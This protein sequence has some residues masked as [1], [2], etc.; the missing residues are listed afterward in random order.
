MPESL[1]LRVD[2]VS[3]QRRSDAWAGAIAYTGVVGVGMM[4]ALAGLG[5]SADPFSLALGV[6]LFGGAAILVRPILGVYLIVFFTLLGDSETMA[7]Y[8]AYRNFSSRE[9]MLYVNDAM[10]FTPVEVW[11]ALTII[12]L[13]VHSAGAREWNLRGRPLVWPLIALALM[14]GVGLFYGVGLRGGNLTVAIWELRPV[15][16]LPVMFI[17]V[18]N[19]FTRVAHYV[20][21]AWVAVAA[22]SIQNVVAILY[23]HSLPPDERAV[24][25]RLTEH[26]ASVHYAWMF[27]LTACL[28]ALRGCS[29]SARLALLVASIPTAYVFVLSQRRAAVVAMVAGFL[30]LAIVLFVRRR[31]LFR[32]VAPISLLVGAMYTAAFWNATGGIGFGARA[33]KSVI[34][35]DQASDRDSSS[36]VYRVLENFNLVFT[37]RT[38]PLT[39]VGFGRPF[40]QPA[41]LPDIS[42]FVFYEYIPH[43]SILWVWLKMGYVGFVILLFIIAATLR[44]GMRASLTLPT[45][46]TLAVTVAA[47]GYVVMYF[48]FAYVD[49]AWDTRSTIFLAVC[50][51]TCVSIGGLARSEE[52]SAWVTPIRSSNSSRD[53]VESRIELEPVWPAPTPLSGSDR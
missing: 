27:L 34:A 12:G 19:L 41:P 45:G 50:T 31:R 52:R 30:V 20:T 21:L 49:I 36:N 7:S 10:T 3:R 24:L 17:A 44:A 48:V 32:V 25:Q 33:V 18:S 11:L 22:I 51:S 46:T 16:Y 35:S 1:P 42:F 26:A 47:L 14:V 6:L 13:F 8:P 29:W 37:V 53:R 5:R 2:S 40:Y 23:Y 43:N 39:G 28:F 15:L 4:V 38:D 9:S